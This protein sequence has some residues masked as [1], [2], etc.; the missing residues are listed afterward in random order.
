MKGIVLAGGS[1]S[2]LSPLT[3]STSKHLL[4]V[5]DKPMV[6]YP[7]ATLMEMG[8]REILLVSTPRDLPRYRLLLGDGHQLGI[9]ISYAEQPEPSGLAEA[10]TLGSDFVGADSVALVLGDNLFHGQDLPRLLR[11]SAEGLDGCVLFGRRVPDPHRYGVAEVG[12]EGSLRSIEEKPGRP[13]SDLAVTGLYL[14]DNDVLDIAAEVKPSDR[15]ELEITDVNLA[16]LEQ[17]RARLVNLG[18]DVLWM[19]AGTEESLLEAALRVRDTARRDGVRVACLEEIAL[20]EGYIDADDCLAL[21][22]EL[23]QSPYAEYV[24][25][26]AV[27]A[28]VRR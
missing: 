7:L 10:F 11:E 14:Y 22:E 27:G 19:D 16:Y 15:G 1:G 23:G 4:P 9:D 5:Y 21:A 18:P 12:P 3:K 26:A 6:H 24:V 28:R 13:R 8:V 17:G 2:R 25:R 20:R